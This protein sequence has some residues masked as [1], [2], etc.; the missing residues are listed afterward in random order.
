MGLVAVPD[1]GHTCAP[2]AMEGSLYENTVW[3]CD[4][5]DT[6]WVARWDDNSWG[7]P[8]WHRLRWYHRTAIKLMRGEN[9]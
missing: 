3:Q 5:C 9:R 6:L 8:N 7:T 1:P 4:H 2:P